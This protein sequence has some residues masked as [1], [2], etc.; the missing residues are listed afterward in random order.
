MSPAQRLV[1]MANQIARNFAA[2]GADA[3]ALAVADHIAAFWDPRMKAQIF[4]VESGGQDP[5]LEPIA[6]HAVALLRDRGAPSPQSAATQFASPGASGG[7][8]AG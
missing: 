2:Q 5:G 3:A 1:Y 4:A 8:D 6:A 7:S